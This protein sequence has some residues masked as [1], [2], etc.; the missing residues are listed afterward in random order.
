MVYV[1]KAVL[2]GYV[3]NTVRV[4]MITVLVAFPDGEA[5]NTCIKI[6]KVFYFL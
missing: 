2:L 1:I 4:S 3:T 5:L 6:L